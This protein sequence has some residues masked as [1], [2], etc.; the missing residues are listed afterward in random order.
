MRLPTTTYALAFLTTTSIVAA[1][2]LPQ[3][4]SLPQPASGLRIPPPNWTPPPN[5]VGIGA[6]NLTEV[7]KRDLQ[8][9][10]PNPAA[11]HPR[12][13][14][15]YACGQL[16]S[17][18]QSDTFQFFTTDAVMLAWNIGHGYEGI[19]RETV[20]LMKVN[21]GGKDTVVGGVTGIF[22]WRN[23][24]FAPAV[25]TLYYVTLRALPHCLIN[26]WIT[27]LV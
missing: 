20:T 17:G 7:E 12:S 4:S 11:L 9:P 22:N 15:A 13:T 24:A 5:C 18:W 25:G 8:S 3:S 26:W 19:T 14:T 1:V 10:E 21:P 16:I 2:S 27:P 23:S 6:H